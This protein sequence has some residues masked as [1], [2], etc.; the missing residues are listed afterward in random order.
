MALKVYVGARYAPKFSGAWDKANEY[1][2]LEVVYTNNQSYV[3]RKTVPANTE[4]T[5]TEYWIKSSDW[6]AQVGQYNANVEQYNANVEQYNTNVEQ[7]QQSVNSFYA[8]TM[9]SYNTKEDMVNDE[10]LK[11]GET[12]LTCGNATVSDGGGGFWQVVGETS[13]NAVALKNGL[14]A[15]RVQLEPYNAVVY[16]DK[17]PK[18]NKTGSTSVTYAL[19]ISDAKSDGIHVYNKVITGSVTGGLVNAVTVKVATWSSVIVNG[20]IK[21]YIKAAPFSSVTVVPYTVTT[22]T[23]DVLCKAAAYNNAVIGINLYIV[24][25]RVQYADTF[26]KEVGA[27]AVMPSETVT[28]NGT[29]SLLVNAG[30]LTLSAFNAN[31]QCPTRVIYVNKVEPGFTANITSLNINIQ[32]TNTTLQA[33]DIFNG[34]TIIMA[35]IP[36]TNLSERSIAVTLSINNN[37]V[38]GTTWIGGNKITGTTGVITSNL[39]FIVKII[40]ADTQRI[41]QIYTLE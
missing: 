26:T 24:N 3:S 33:S 9:H 25:N 40:G 28:V 5:N 8:D 23:D 41:A 30:V 34:E 16:H 39:K 20:I 10:M 13:A 31:Y 36:Y 12:L 32:T 21:L 38:V 7:Y 37:S 6:N 29:T 4:I 1:S 2:A 14:F 19:D 27:P 17:T 18:F 15:I 22:A 11:L 35:T